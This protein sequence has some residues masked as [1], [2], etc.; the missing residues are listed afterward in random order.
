MQLK[1]ATSYKLSL[2]LQYAVLFQLLTI[3]FYVVYF[4]TDRRHTVGLEDIDL[5]LLLAVFPGALVGFA[6]EF[7][8]RRK[9]K[10]DPFILALFY[11]T[12][13]NTLIL[14][15]A[16]LILGLLVGYKSWTGFFKISLFYALQILVAISIFQVRRYVGRGRIIQ[17]LTGKYI[18]PT[19]ENNLIMFVDLKASTTLADS[20]DTKIYSEFIRDFISDISEPIYLYHGRIYQYVG[21]EVVVY[22]KLNKNKRKNTRPIR[23]FVGMMDIIDKRKDYYLE[24]YGLIPEFKAGMHGGPLIVAEV[25]ELKKEIA[26]HGRVMNTTARIQEKCNELKTN[27]LIS[28]NILSE[29]ELAPDFV[30]FSQGKFLL[31]G[32]VEKIELFTVEKADSVGEKK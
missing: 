11:R 4:L 21:D 30:P 25:G 12:F 28:E 32:K 20:L 10:R 14:A 8:L 7:I 24:R 29:T 1:P 2:V 17:F 3:F 19:W 26:F 23:C 22:W 15:F 31:K 27:F 6:D 9:F 18:H 16:L 5:R 13:I